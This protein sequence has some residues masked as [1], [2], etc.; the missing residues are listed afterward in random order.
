MFDFSISKIN[1]RI[2]SI[3]PMNKLIMK[4]V[5]ETKAGVEH[6]THLK[7]ESEIRLPGVVASEVP[8]ELVD[9]RVACNPEV[10]NGRAVLVTSELNTAAEIHKPSAVKVL[11]DVCTLMV[12]Q[13]MEAG[14]KHITVQE[15]IDKLESK[16]RSPR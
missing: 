7:S 14:V 6:V 2:I 9:L 5:P 15:T 1:M 12:V 16:V 10:C 4:K 11:T 13:E 3:A 8:M